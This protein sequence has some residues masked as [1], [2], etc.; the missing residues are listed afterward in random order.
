M[1][2]LSRVSVFA[3]ISPVPLT[4]VVLPLSELVTFTL[5]AKSMVAESAS[6]AV[7][8]INFFVVVIVV[9]VSF[10]GA[11]NVSMGRVISPIVHEAELQGEDM[12]I[13]RNNQTE[14]AGDKFDKHQ[15]EAVERYATAQ[16]KAHRKFGTAASL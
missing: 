3:I 8:R 7:K 4:F 12:L 10:Y 2:N 1:V 13:F 14:R 11:P 16:Q 15:G 5:H 6:V 9:F